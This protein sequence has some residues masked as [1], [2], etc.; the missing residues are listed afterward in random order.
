MVLLWRCCLKL[1][2]IGANLHRSV[3]QLPGEVE[4]AVVIHPG[5][6]DDEAGHAVDA[7]LACPGV[8]GAH[9]FQVLVAVQVFAR[10][11]VRGQVMV[12]IL[13]TIGRKKLFQRPATES[14]RVG[15]YVYR[16]WFLPDIFDYLALMTTRRASAKA[17]FPI[18]KLLLIC[19]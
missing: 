16:H 6:G 4:V 7:D 10:L 12:L 2:R 11:R 19:K 13:N 8:L 5:L 18:C 17:L 15:V 9:Q 1:D 3:H 14:T